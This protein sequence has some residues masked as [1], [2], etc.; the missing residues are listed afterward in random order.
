MARA[1][2]AARCKGECQIGTGGPAG[3]G[4]GVCS[5]RSARRA[6]HEL[7]LALAEWRQWRILPALKSSLRDIC[8]LAVAYENEG[9]VEIRGDGH[10][11]QPRVAAPTEF[12]A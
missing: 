9:G 11:R 8:R 1:V 5:S 6:A 4:S 7:G 10:G 12:T 2:C 3:M